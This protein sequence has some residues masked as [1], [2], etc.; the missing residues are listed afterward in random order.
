MYCQKCGNTAVG[1]IGQHL[2]SSDEIKMKIDKE[3]FES[4]F[5]ETEQIKSDA[6]I[7]K[8]GMTSVKVLNIS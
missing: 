2:T 4:T 5:A 8:A 1:I 6:N 7:H 3:L